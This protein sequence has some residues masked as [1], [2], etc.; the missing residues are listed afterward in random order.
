PE[1]AVVGEP[2]VEG[3]LGAAPGVSLEARAEPAAVAL[4]AAALFFP[5]DAGPVFLVDVARVFPVDAEPD[6]ARSDAAVVEA[7]LAAVGALAIDDR[8]DPAGRGCPGAVRRLRV[9]IHQM[10]AARSA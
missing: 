3:A 9:G 7:A 6:A 4:P 10:R 8:R 2:G 1:V 5:G